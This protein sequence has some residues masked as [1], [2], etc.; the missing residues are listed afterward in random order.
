[1]SNLSR[2]FERHSSHIIGTYARW[3]MLFG[4]TFIAAARSGVVE[5]RAG[6]S[7]HAARLDAFAGRE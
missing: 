2:Q 5:A 3:Q 4:K 7:R 6:T 1:M